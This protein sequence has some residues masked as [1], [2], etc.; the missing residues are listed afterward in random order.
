MKR[1]VVL[2]DFSI[3]S[4]PLLQMAY[5]WKEHFGMG[6]VFINRVP[7]LVPAI[8]D[9]KTRTQVIKHEKED[10]KKNFLKILDKNDLTQ[11]EGI[12]L[13]IDNPLIPFLK[14]YLQPDDILLLGLKGTGFLKK[15]LI[16][17]TATEIINQLNNLVIGVPKNIDR[18]IPKKLVLACHP[19][20]PVNENSLKQLL[21]AIGNNLEELELLTIINQKSEEEESTSYLQKLSHGLN[22]QLPKKFNIYLGK[23]AFSEIKSKYRNQQEIFIVLQKGSRNLNDQL[24]RKLFINDLIHDGNTPLIILPS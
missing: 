8:A 22:E 1:L 15:Y 24:F 2:L 12:F 6:L 9:E 17:S 19:K 16:G 7:G 5:Q 14:T 11:G 13:A 10:A 23:D 3:Y 20:Y 18:N 21:G 4:S